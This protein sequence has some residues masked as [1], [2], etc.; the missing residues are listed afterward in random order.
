MQG[1]YTNVSDVVGNPV[2]DDGTDI[3]GLADVTDEDPSNHFGVLA[4]IDIEKATNGQDAD[5]P[6]GPL[7]AVGS[8][9]TFTYVVTNTGNVALGSVLVTDD[10]GTPGDTSDD[11]APL[12]IGGDTD[13]DDLLDLTETWTYEA[14]RTVVQGQ[15]TN[16]S[17]VVGNPVEDDGT[18]IPGLADV[19]DEDP[20]NHFG[21][22]GGIDIEKYTGTGEF[23]F[24]P[25]GGQFQI[26]ETP[27]DPVA[28]DAQGN[29]VAVWTGGYFGVYARRYRADGAARGAEFQVNST[30]MSMSFE[31]Q[32]GMADNGDFVVVWSGG[33]IAAN[34]HDVFGQ[35]Y[36]A[37]GARRGGQFRINSTTAGDQTR[38][39]IAMDADGDFVVVWQGP[40]GDGNGVF[41]QRY[42]AA[43]V[44][45]GGQFRVNAT[46]VGEQNEPS[47]AMDANG[48]FVVTYTGGNSSVWARRYSAAG[49]AQTDTAVRVSPS[50]DPP[51]TDSAVAMDADGDYVIVY[52]SADADG[53]GLLT[54]SAGV[55]AQRYNS[56]GVAQGGLFRVNTHTTNDQ[57]DPAVAMD[58]A[59]DFLV[60]WTQMYPAP[61]NYGI[62]GQLFDRD[63]SRHGGEFR[64]NHEWQPG[65]WS[66][67]AMDAD[68]DAVIVWTGMDGRWYSFG[69]LY[70]AEH[71]MEDADAPT[72]PRL[73]T[74]SDVTWT[75]EVRNTSGVPLSHI[76]V[77]DD[78]GTPGDPGDDFN[79]PPV[80]SGG[81][82]V[83]DVDHDNK[84]DVNEVWLYEATGTVQRGQ[85][86]N[87]SVVTGRRPDDVPVTDR[88]PSH[89]FGLHPG[90][91]I[92]KATNGEDAD[93][94]TGPA[95]AVGGPVTWTYVVTNT[96]NIPL[97]NVVVTDDQ[98]VTPVFAGGDTNGDG[99]LNVTETWTYRATGRAELGQ[100]A[101]EGT[102]TGKDR[103]GR[104]V[105]DR[106]PSHY[107][108]LGAEIDIEKATNGQDA[109]VPTGPLLTPGST[110]TF[111][112]VVKNTGDVALADVVVTDDNGTSGDTSDD[113]APAFTGGDTDGDGL[114]DLT[115]TWTYEADRAVTAG[116]YTNMSD[117][118]GNPVEDDGTDIPGLADVSDADPS[119]HFG[120]LA[121]ID[122]EKA[123]NAADPD[124]PTAAEDADTMPGPSVPVGSTVT[125]TYQVT[126]TGNVALQFL[127]L[128]DD[129]G[130][131]LDLGDDLGPTPV[132]DGGAVRGDVD[133]DGLIDPAMGGQPAETWLFTATGTAQ[134][135][136]Y[137]NNAT[138]TA[139]PVTPVGDD[140]PGLPDVF[141]EDPSHYF[142]VRA[143]IDIEKATNG[144]DADSPTGPVLA[145][146][147]TATFTYVVTNTGVVA[148]S[149][150]VVTD[151]NGTPGDTS[152]DFAPT[153]VGG[154]T[155]G[156]DLLDPTETWTYE[157]ERV[158]TVGQYT[159]DSDVVGNPVEDDGTD[160][161]G[162][163]DVTD[164]DPSNHVGMA[165]GIDIE[166][167]TGTGDIEFG[168]AGGQFQIGNTPYDPVAMD[169]QGN[170]VAVWTGLDSSAYGVYA[171]RFRADGTPRGA[172]FV[173]NTYT[174]A[175]QWEPEVAM[176]DNGDFV[177]VWSGDIKDGS[178]YGIFGQRFSAAGARRG[179]EFQI[180]TTT[181]GAQKLPDVAMDANGDFVVVW[182]GPDAD[183]NGVFGQRYSA[184]GVRQGGQ[185]R[186]NATAAS[187]QN[188]PSV[189]MD[190]TGK[191]V[192]TYT[193]GFSS[194]WAR[195][196]SAT[197]AAQT[198]T[199]VRVSPSGDP[200]SKD[201]AVA[202][203]ADGDYVIV[204]ERADANGVG[205]FARRYNSS[206]VARGERFRVNTYTTSTQHDPAV[207]M[208]DV[209]DFLITWASLSQGS[210][211]YGI[212]GQL[213]D[214]S[215]SRHGSEFRVNG[216]GQIGQWPSVAM[217]ADGDAVVVWTGLDGRWYS[218]GRLY[219]A[220]GVMEDA[221]TPTGPRLPTGSDVVWTYEVRN[222]SGVQL[223]NI[224]V[225]DD[226]G[227]PGDPSDDFNPPPVRS[228]GFNVGDVD[229]DNRLDVNE[230]WLYEAT[231]IVERGQYGNW[232][233]VTGQRPDGVPVSDND[234]SHYFGLKP[235]VHIEKATNGEDAD[236][237]T[238][239]EI[240]EDNP[241]VWTYV[242]TNTG[243]IP[244]YN[245][246]VTDDQGVTP[247][248]VGGDANGDGLLNVTETWTYRAT[249]TAEIGQYANVGKVTGKDRFGR[250]VTDEDPSH[251]IGVGQRIDI[252]KWTNGTT[253]LADWDYRKTIAVDHEKVSA[254]L[255]NFPV[256]I[257]LSSD[258]DLAAR[259]RNDGGD[260]LFAM[261]STAP[262]IP[263]LNYQKLD[264]EI[265]H[266]DGDT[267][268]LDA[269]VKVPA[270][271]ASADTE[272]YMFYGN[273]T[274]TDLQNPRGVWSDYEA[275]W[276]LDEGGKGVRTDSAGNMNATP[277]AYEG[278]G[279]EAVSGQI[280]G[281]D[282][283]G[284]VDDYLEAG[285]GVA[286]GATNATVTVSFWARGD[287]PV[288]SNER[289]NSGEG[290]GRIWL[291]EGGNLIYTVHNRPTAPYSVKVNSTLGSDTSQWNH[292]VVSMNGPSNAY[293]FMI[294][295]QS[296]TESLGFA[297]GST[298]YENLEIG[299]YRNYTYSEYYFDGSLDE[300]RVAGKV[301][302][303]AWGETEY[304]NQVDPPQ[305]VTVS[306][307]ETGGWASW[308]MGSLPSVG[309]N[310]DSAADPNIPKILPGGDVVWSYRVQ[311][312]GSVA[313]SNV[314]VT[315]DN[316]TSDPADD[317]LV[318]PLL[319][320]AGTHN[321]G[322]LDKDNELDVGEKWWFQAT[323]T[324]QEGP[325]VN[326][327]T[328]TGET[329]GGI[330]VEDSDPSRYIG[331]GADIHIEK[332]TNGWDA[333][334]GPGPMLTVYPHGYVTM[335]T[336]T[337]RVSNPGLLPISNVVVVDD[338]G[339]P[340][341]AADDFR[342]DPV[343][344]GAYNVGDADHDN[345]LD[346]GEV[347]RYK[348]TRRAVV[349][350][351][352]NWGKVTGKDPSGK[353]VS[354]R[355]PS[356]YVGMQGIDPGDFVW[357]DVNRNGIQDAGEPGI[358]GV[359]I[360]LYRV[361]AAGAE[362][363]VGSMASDAMGSYGFVVS[364]DTYRLQF[365]APEGWQFTRADRGDD[366]TRDSDADPLT[367]STEAFVVEEE[368]MTRDAGLYQPVEASA[369]RLA[370]ELGWAR[371]PVPSEGLAR[372]LQRR[373]AKAAPAVA[374]RWLFD[375]A[376]RGPLQVLGSG[377]ADL[378]KAP[379]R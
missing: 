230:L 312:A 41:G 253:S 284:G 53:G 371:G 218:F 113:F 38:V 102:V 221:D 319:N 13:G 344:A 54:D 203:D 251:Y 153:F 39:D 341:N 370:L 239:P 89:Y 132:F 152:D 358:E 359:T 23:S 254:D 238:G 265:T 110:A 331:V 46:A 95:I 92:E 311:N 176:A 339:T 236:V 140:I 348:E 298:L 143:A 104:T 118:V 137:E 289:K 190:A 130:T 354:D 131:P 314:S 73:P 6:T 67:V 74:G 158:V 4:A 335:V 365:H 47:V 82:N 194:V 44:Q 58:D 328:V 349:G 304:N 209:G 112:Y 184:A 200:A 205:V 343:K 278:G 5:N 160:I 185:F 252:E 24:G 216:A 273:P 138:A 22:A 213:F 77:T 268:R 166:K 119:N 222:T 210:A 333:D 198:A 368:D 26:G 19:T 114:L 50:G 363:L 247:T 21:T 149:N 364:A 87:W 235:G 287:G 342:P 315:D 125:W 55:F 212:Y 193:G 40:D 188:E 285:T 69:R 297:N 178:S 318:A 356:H 329:P 336:W 56:A 324:A 367:G 360:D 294:N 211:G 204:Y 281:A 280:G 321:R 255:T 127:S 215:G 259:A 379:V 237:P 2:E 148:L 357:H 103:F 196:Y 72:G 332:A 28:M 150:V 305:F 30:A 109:D 68:G 180:N 156:D 59:G 169:A 172:E 229:H 139:N 48:N 320:A 217:D 208:D 269:W 373:A 61:G 14:S 93:M 9:A 225:T 70:N 107:I 244:L 146:G 78:N 214:S 291:N 154:D 303:L 351:Y 264:F 115:E 256:L 75:Y 249:G 64:A 292:Y 129:N 97:R 283:L 377:L 32:A 355:D 121:A 85:Y 65:Q 220:E 276:H 162:L 186:V 347:W 116:Q 86:E 307:Q 142:G 338:H 295:G 11:F 15:Y 79:P 17:D 122:I 274:A 293:T 43:G 12:F 57:I 309:A 322:D 199:A 258:A 161:P 3:P 134:L 108:G 323:G 241:V 224:V 223:S 308:G 233:V 296:Q 88:D 174:T 316:G 310:A 301:Q 352:G 27:Y 327:S 101:N 206:G 207:A 173:V 98:G 227:T 165:G 10:N 350:H 372:L 376:D 124:N 275:V 202:M 1:Q 228:G 91:D 37:S 378:L 145:V 257:S 167:Y 99:L 84:L 330:T 126:N 177:V 191:F 45:R 34:A 299:R 182:Q 313:L 141:D 25:S 133:Q 117:V 60:T 66:S 353:I 279:Q 120:V 8:T 226:N 326:W 187:E 263:H 111:T 29:F 366:D 290:G 248:F 300:V 147:S 369:R 144:E 94:P 334:A 277:V 337:Y 163:A 325:Y 243:N 181:S 179:G 201:S 7:L 106:D 128:T 302:S 345:K 36:S 90:V 242:V 171:R 96:G 195:R 266:F 20:S 192:V 16:V 170:F 267:G 159:N 374:P 42:S 189:A 155:D 52:E 49:V 157:A 286:L 288:L 272:I 136:Q 35:R 33:A 282:R 135:G 232:S 262:N 219:N 62:Y 105:R 18:D 340:A 71:V 168:P 83:G 175:M 306:S 270:L 76:V 362:E 246:T 245:V 80:L 151:D 317:F 231:G 250:R 31:P 240:T 375:G 100:Y 197:G 81:F 261:P 234:P 63:G 183:G 123:T 361:D 260:I 346:P 271:S 164:E 51:S